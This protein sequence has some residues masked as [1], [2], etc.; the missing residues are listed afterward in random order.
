MSRVSGKTYFTYVLWSPSARRFY[1]GI[2]D[3]PLRRLLQHNQ[4]VSRWTERYRPWTLILVE[5]FGSYR[6][7]RKRE[8]QLKAQKSGQGFFALTGLD[9]ILYGRAGSALRS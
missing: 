2:S 8:L 7:A 4:G 1:I 5:R 9:P 6:E 3:S